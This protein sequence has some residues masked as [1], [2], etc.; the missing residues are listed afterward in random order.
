MSVTKQVIVGDSASAQKAYAD[1]ARQVVKLEEQIG[2]QGTTTDRV[3]GRSK[4]MLEGINGLLRQQLTNIAATA[5]AVLSLGQA[6]SMAKAAA[7]DYMNTSDR[8]R[9]AKVDIAQAQTTLALNTLNKEDFQR[10]QAD[11]SAIAKQTN[12]SNIAALTEAYSTAANA[13]PGATPEERR[14]NAYDAVL[15]GASLTKHRPDLLDSFV[16]GSLDVASSA[17]V[18]PQEANSLNLTAGKF[19]RIS[20]PERQQRAISQTVASMTASSD[21]S[22]P[23]KRKKAA[24][25]AAEFWAALNRASKDDRGEMSRTASGTFGSYSDEAFTRGIETNVPGLPFPIRI[26][27]KED[28]GDPVGR[29]EALQKDANFGK[30]FVEKYKFANEGGYDSRMRQA[31]LDPEHSEF[32]QMLKEAKGAVGYDAEIYGSAKE[33]IDAGSKQL[34]TA[35]RDQATETRNAIA[36]LEGLDQ[37][38]LAAEA[39]KIRD[40]ALET[41]AGYGFTGGYIPEAIFGGLTN[42]GEDRFG[43]ESG[44]AAF[45]TQQLERKVSGIKRGALVQEGK[46]GSPFLGTNKDV[47]R[48]LTTEEKEA[49]RTLTEAINALK[50]ILEQQR[51]LQ[52]RQLQETSGKRPS[53]AP[54]ARA[55][56]GRHRER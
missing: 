54:A 12:F 2:K 53:S 46:Y 14:K 23:E 7:E 18:S 44:A 51:E 52:E 40:K 35:G 49:T 6:W 38:S 34:E 20:N 43:F 30:A 4:G 36:K 22:T 9:Q 45:A 55:E 8:I 5:T 41:T 47:Y 3:Q 28:P 15:Q 19:A 24:E 17:G 56:A 39:R 13:A 27:P 50:P 26:K 29:L 25:S 21:V 16:G 48:E 11:I 32:A 33:V 10:A 37:R 42:W 31:I 1:L